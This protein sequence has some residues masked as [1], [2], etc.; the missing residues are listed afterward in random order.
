MV[1]IH[2]P[3]KKLFYWGFR[4]LIV[5]VPTL[6][7]SYFSYKTAVVQAR[8]S[9][10]ST[11]EAGYKEHNYVLQQVQ[12][13]LQRQS[14][15]LARLDGEVEALRGFIMEAPPATHEHEHKHGV[16]ATKVITLGE[17]QVQGFSGIG[18]AAGGAGPV[19]AVSESPSVPPAAVFKPIKLP[20]SLEAALAAMQDSGVQSSSPAKKP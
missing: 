3:N 6:I 7:T 4:A 11:A 8:E 14:I 5:I 15:A 16:K 2:D 20:N 13:E 10:L 18:A 1:A 19:A 9:S 17:I 12:D